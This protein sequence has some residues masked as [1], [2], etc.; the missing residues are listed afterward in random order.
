MSSLSSITTLPPSY[1]N[2]R[3]QWDFWSTLFPKS[4]NEPS[5]YVKCLFLEESKKWIPYIYF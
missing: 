5:N 4:H 1:Y 2:A 3:C